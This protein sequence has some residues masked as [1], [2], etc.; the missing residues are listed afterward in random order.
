FDG[1]LKQVTTGNWDVIE[2]LGVDDKNT[3]IYYTSAENGPIHES[4]YKIGLDGKKKKLISSATGSSSAE[5]SNGMKFFIKTYSNANTPPIYSLCDNAGKELTILENNAGL[6]ARA[7][8]FKFSPKE[9]V[10]FNGTTEKLNGWMIKPANFDPQKKY[11]VYINIYGG[12]GSN[13][14]S[15]SWGGVN[16]AY[17]QLLAQN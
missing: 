17:H 8:Q 13:M 12:P 4:I 15:D 2:F 6:K 9:F 3:T 5:F 1:D 7:E 10:T 16:L 14:V 11:P